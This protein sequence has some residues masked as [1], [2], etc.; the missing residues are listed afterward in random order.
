MA[1][2]ILS[3]FSPDAVMGTGGYASFPCVYAATHKG[4]PTLIHE[5]NAHA[6]MAHRWL[7][8]RVSKICVSY[9]NMERYFS[10]K[11][12][13]YT[14][15][16]LRSSLYQLPGV[17]S[18]RAHFKLDAK[19]ATLLVW[20]GSWEQG[21][22]MKRYWLLRRAGRRLLFL[23]NCYGLP[24]RLIMRRWCRDGFFAGFLGLYIVLCKGY[25]ICLCV[26]GC[27]IGTRRGFE[28]CRACLCV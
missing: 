17:S 3:R 28:Y 7:A 26:G 19:K 15:T 25:G 2:R 12:L 24:V 14:G 16:P 9:E 5:S 27:G 4:I 22:L 11:K 18:A 10:P 21:A 6:G 20:G 13:I 23:Y 8:R 1:W